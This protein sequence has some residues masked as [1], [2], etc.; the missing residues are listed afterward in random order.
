LS[1]LADEAYWLI[2]RRSWEHDWP[3][4]WFSSILRNESLCADS[5]YRIWC[6]AHQLDLVVK[7]AVNHLD[8]SEVFIFLKVL[9]EVIAYLRRQKKLIFEMGSRCPYYITVR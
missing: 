5:F 8:E 9:T 7:A 1:R 2:Y 4:C 6:L 3:Q